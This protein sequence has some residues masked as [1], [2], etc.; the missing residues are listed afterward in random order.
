MAR[1]QEV[2]HSISAKE[3]PQVVQIDRDLYFGPIHPNNIGQLRR[4]NETI[5]PIEY[6]EKFY[7]G[8]VKAPQ[9]LVKLAHYKDLTVGS[10][11][12]RLETKEDGEMMYIMT[13][14]VLPKYRGMG[15]G[16]KLVE[17]ITECAKTVYHCK[18]VR[19]HVWVTNTKAM[20]FYKKLGF[21]VGEVAKGY[22]KNVSP[23]DAHIVEKLFVE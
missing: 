3:Q 11:C 23:P 20:D 21:T 9:D 10:I 16:T 5:L 13:L 6:E 8:I 4:L 12:C 17:Y 7:N 15:I 19:L 1:T 18:G 22:Y 2:Q 14:G